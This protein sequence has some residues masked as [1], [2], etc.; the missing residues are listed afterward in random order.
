MTRLGMVKEDRFERN[1]IAFLPENDAHCFMNYKLVFSCVTLLGIISPVA[2]SPV[3]IEVPTT[4][5]IAQ[6]TTALSRAQYLFVSRVE[7]FNAENSKLDPVKKNIVFAGDSLTHGFN[8]AKALPEFPV[9]NRGIASDGLCDFPSGRNLWRGLT[10]R[11]DESIYACNPS[12]LFLLIGT[13]DI[14]PTD[15]PMD[16]WR[17]AYKYVLTKTRAK[18][19]ELKIIVVTCP[20]TG[21]AYAR[22]E[23]F[24]PRVKEWNDFLRDYARQENHE[25]I[26]LYKLLADDQGL[27]PTELTRDG[28][29]FNQAGYD[30]WLV[31]IRK[32]LEKK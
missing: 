7:E 17:G 31:E 9:L 30:R 20:P 21:T 29:H 22:R 11:M 12:H 15:I 5:S 13:N 28:L 3:I 4:A 32:V 27:L 25:L 6:T 19:P 10:R 26:D 16:Y 2:S 14:G 24:N 1:F 8:F 18:F 23:T